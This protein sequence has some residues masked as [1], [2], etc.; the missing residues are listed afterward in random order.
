M[1]IQENI[2]SLF[3]D[4]TAFG[5]MSE[6]IIFKDNPQMNQLIKSEIEAEKS[7][8]KLILHLSIL[9]RRQNPDK[10]HQSTL[11]KKKNQKRASII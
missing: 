9:K 11:E 2:Q 1:K 4:F 7:I 6:K 5:E 8:G 3:K 10:K